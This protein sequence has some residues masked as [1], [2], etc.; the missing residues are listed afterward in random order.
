MTMEMKE[1]KIL[2]LIDVLNSGGAERQISYLAI[3]LK[4]AECEV[5]L[6][7]FYDGNFY[8]DDLK[9][10]GIVVEVH[11]EGSNGLKRAKVIAQI[12]RTWSPDLVVAYKNGTSMAACIAR[13]C[14]CK[15]RLIVSERNTTQKLVFRERMRFFSCRW[16]DVI[17][18]NSYSQARYIEEHFPKLA[19][20]TK[21]ITNVVDIDKFHPSKTREKHNVLRVVTVGRIA[22]QKNVLTYLDALKILQCQQ[23]D[24]HVDWYGDSLEHWDYWKVVAEKQVKLGLE[25]YISFHDPCQSIDKVYR[26]ADVFCLPSI[27][28]GFPNVLVEAMA[29]GLPVACSRVC[30]NPFIVKDLENGYLFDPRRPIDIAEKIKSLCALSEN[31]RQAIGTRNREKI[32]NL[33]SPKTFVRKYLDCIQ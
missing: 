1:K 6:C 18:P 28:E 20:K 10:A 9:K 13:R 17:V 22:P 24:I 3:Y 30:D 31:E 25:N 33:C 26:D 2:L 7:T 14:L 12:V 5:R 29:S 19:R 21:V 15:F 8:Y 27:Y 23:L 32:K 16:A 4:K 11:H